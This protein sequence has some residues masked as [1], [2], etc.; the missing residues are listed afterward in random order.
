MGIRP[1]TSVVY[2]IKLLQKETIAFEAFMKDKPRDWFLAKLIQQELSK[3]TKNQ[4][5]DIYFSHYF[6]KLIKDSG[7]ANLKHCKPIRPFWSGMT[8]KQIDFICEDLDSA[9]TVY[10]GTFGRKKEIPVN[11]CWPE[12]E[13]EFGIKNV[14]GLISQ[15]SNDS[16]IDYCLLDI[17]KIKEDKTIIIQGTRPWETGTSRLKKDRVWYTYNCE[18]L[19]PKILVSE[20]QYE[21]ILTQISIQKG[22]TKQQYIAK[23]K[24]IW[25]KYHAHLKPYKIYS[26]DGWG[27]TN[28]YFYPVDMLFKLISEYVPEIK[29]D[30]MR[31]EK[32]L[33]FYWS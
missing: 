33:C 22:G 7:F 31:L 23:K 30:D 6:V 27:G 26:C 24:A 5:Y 13:P 20:K 4:Y 18:N 32:L 3:K 14:L 8:K 19:I 29:Y 25:D 21:E 15:T 9:L 1:H 17:L 11:I 12:S 16:S 10:L 2:G 28:F